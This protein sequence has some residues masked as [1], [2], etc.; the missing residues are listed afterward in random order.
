LGKALLAKDFNRGQGKKLVTTLHRW[1]D[2]ENAQDGDEVKKFL[3]SS[4]PLPKET[5]AKT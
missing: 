3:S 2:E 4:I 5:K 1:A